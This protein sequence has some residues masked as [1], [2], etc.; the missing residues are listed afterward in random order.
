VLVALVA[1][2]GG[3]LALIGGGGGHPG[4]HGP[5][6]SSR[7][8]RVCVAARAEARAVATR[9]LRVPV[10][11]TQPVSVTERAGSNA[12]TISEKVVERAVA[13]RK[14]EVRQG[15]VGPGRA[16]A[17]RATSDEARGAALTRAYKRAQAAARARARR[18]AAA[19]LHALATR[20]LPALVASA[21]RA[22]DARARS[23]A[24]AVRRELVARARAQVP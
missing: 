16:C 15:A 3:A 5:I 10:S 6:R 20:Q 17:R 8:A 9:V 7:P 4:S 1:A 18:A 11:V 24:N 2:L 22:L 13:T 23:A 21:R 19:S 12:V 14:L